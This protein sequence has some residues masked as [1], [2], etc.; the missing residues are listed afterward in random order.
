MWSGG[1]VGA[2]GEAVCLGKELLIPQIFTEH[3]VHASLQLGLGSCII[4][5]PSETHKISSSAEPVHE[6]RNLDTGPCTSLRSSQTRVLEPGDYA[7]GSTGIG[8]KK[9]RNFNIEK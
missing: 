9:Y 6:M 8:G 5:G 1:R 3:L 2:R 4:Y 7:R